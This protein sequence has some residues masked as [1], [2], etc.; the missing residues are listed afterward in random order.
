MTKFTVQNQRQTGTALAMFCLQRNKAVG[1]PP[2][3]SIEAR[4]EDGIVIGYL[5]RSG[6]CKDEWES[7]R[8]TAGY[9]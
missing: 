7:I 5:H 2:D 6:P 8:S 4:D 3:L 1:P 9:K